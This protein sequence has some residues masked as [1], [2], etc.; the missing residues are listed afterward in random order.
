MS[1]LLQIRGIYNNL[2]SFMLISD[3]VRFQRASATL[4][5]GLTRREWE[6]I[7]DGAAFEENVASSSVFDSCLWT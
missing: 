1:S 4:H 3:M 6:G 7:L 5:S 2:D